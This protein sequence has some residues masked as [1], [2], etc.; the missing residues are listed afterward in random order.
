MPII[1]LAV[2]EVRGPDGTRFKLRTALSPAVCKQARAQRG[3]RGMSQLSEAAGG[4]ALAKLVEGLEAGRDAGE[5]A[6]EVN[7][8]LGEDTPEEGAPGKDGVNWDS[9][10]LDWASARL[11][12]VWGYQDDK[13]RNVPVTTENVEFLD[14]ETR[15]WLHG[16]CKSAMREYLPK[17]AVEGNS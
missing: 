9:F 10:D 11:V 4:A 13:G 12:R 2:E 6:K 8:E 14:P 1:G 15:D 17:D 7:A 3:L 5:L 16:K